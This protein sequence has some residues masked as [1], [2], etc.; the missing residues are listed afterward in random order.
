[1]VVGLSRAKPV[2]RAVRS[3][4]TTVVGTVV[5]SAVTLA[6]LPGFLSAVIDI[7]AEA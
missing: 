7:A 1:V 6:A 4:T 2:V 3:R 5:L